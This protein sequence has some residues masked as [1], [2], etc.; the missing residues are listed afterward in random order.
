M[1][2]AALQNDCNLF[3]RLYISCQIRSG[4]LDAFF[5]HENQATPP[6]L[7]IGGEIWL[8]TKAD[9]LECLEV[10]KFQ[11]ANAPIVD[12]K[13]LDGAAVVQMLNPGA[14]K[15]FQEY[16]DTV[17]L[18]YVFQQLSTAKRVDIVWDE[19]ILHS[20]K[21]VTRQKR[22][23]GI[24][25]RVTSTTQLPKNWRDFLHK[26]ENK[27]ELFNFLLQQIACSIT[28]EGKVIYATNGVT[29]LSTSD[30]D[31]TNL[32]PCSHE[33][34]DTCLLLHARD[35]VQKGCR[36]LWIRTVYT[37]VLILAIAMFSHINPDKLWI[38]SGSKLHFR[39]IPVHEIVRGLDPSM[40]KTLLVFHASTGCDTVS[41][42]G[43]RAKKTAWN[44]WK[45]FPDVTKAFEDLILMEESINDL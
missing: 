3:S 14:V 32:S 6:S 33:E 13:L 35:A 44:V 20:L 38:A 29:V 23:K 41:A 31:V 26:N 4:D 34:A 8:G 5:S 45:V 2:V 37:D 24:R 11:V 9:L 28:D 17:F 15:T 19:Y 40:C 42:F 7:S 30:A 25:R 16:A 43:G 22:G 18:P 39:Y 1:Q 21:N 12:V 36:K 10:E 27:A